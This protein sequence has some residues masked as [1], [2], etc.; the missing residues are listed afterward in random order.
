EV[1]V[2]MLNPHV[3]QEFYTDPAYLW[4]RNSFLEMAQDAEGETYNCTGGGILFG[5]EIHWM[6]LPEFLSTCKT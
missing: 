2:R 1:Y 4:Y 6:S 3:N 5:S